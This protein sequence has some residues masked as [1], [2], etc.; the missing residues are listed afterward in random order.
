[1][2]DKSVAGVRFEDDV[3]DFAALSANL[4]DFVAAAAAAVD[5]PAE[6]GAS[7]RSDLSAVG[8]KLV[9]FTSAASRLISARSS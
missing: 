9:L 8:V 5:L 7:A 1:M 2:G 4:R 3:N 6:L